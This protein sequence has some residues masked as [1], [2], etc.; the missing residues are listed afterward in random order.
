MNFIDE[1][2]TDEQ[3]ED[4]NDQLDAEF[5]EREPGSTPITYPPPTPVDVEALDRYLAELVRRP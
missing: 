2:P 4:V 5:A 3:L 1:L